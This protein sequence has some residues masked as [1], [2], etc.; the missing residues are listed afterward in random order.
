M[1]APASPEFRLPQGAALGSQED[2]GSRYIGLGGAAF[3]VVLLVYEFVTRLV[4]APLSPVAIFTYGAVGVFVGAL[5]WVGLVLGKPGPDVVRVDAVGIHLIRKGRS[6]RAH[7]WDDPR[8][9]LELQ[10]LT[11]DDRAE[12]I[13]TMSLYN[14]RPVPGGTLRGLTPECFAGIMTAATARG[15]CIDST[16]AAR[17]HFPGGQILTIGPASSAVPG[18]G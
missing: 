12:S 2:L 3:F 8:F 7:R 1:A 16:S 11:G 10:D 6:L 17:Y 14:W 18:R 15:M 4:A 5:L 9:N 13:A